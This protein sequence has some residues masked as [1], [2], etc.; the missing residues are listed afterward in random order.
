MP[1]DANKGP[2]CAH[3]PVAH[4]SGEKMVH[5]EESW[6]GELPSSSFLDIPGAA[7]GL[8]NLA[9]SP[10]AVSSD[11]DHVLAS[12]G[13]RCPSIPPESGAQTQ[14]PQTALLAESYGSDQCSSIWWSFSEGVGG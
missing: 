6:A 12:S 4:S 10:K 11:L 2:G 5:A 3:P 14:P 7:R 8:E 13:S 9:D 1:P